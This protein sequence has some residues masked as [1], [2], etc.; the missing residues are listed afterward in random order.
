MLRATTQVFTVLTILIH[1]IVQTDTNTP[2]HSPSTQ[3]MFFGA[4]SLCVCGWNNSSSIST[5]VYECVAAVKEFLH[6]VID[7][8]SELFWA[9][10][11][12][13]ILYH[14]SAEDTSKHAGV[15]L[16][17]MCV[18]VVSLLVVSAGSL[19]KH[20]DRWKFHRSPLGTYTCSALTSITE[21]QMFLCLKPGQL[22][23]RKSCCFT[24]E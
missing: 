22:G 13:L 3:Q 2:T 9:S 24:L 17:V 4:V 15:F 11:S 10:S 12:R 1:I 7:Q 16:S 5:V 6:L 18:H 8:H 14:A 23:I 21:L 20:F 19:S